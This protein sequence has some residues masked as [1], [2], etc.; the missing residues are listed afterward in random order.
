MDFVRPTTPHSRPLSSE[1]LYYK[2]TSGF[3]NLVEA[4]KFESRAIIKEPP[5]TSRGPLCASG[6][7]PID[8]QTNIRCRQLSAVDRR[9]APETPQMGLNAFFDAYHGA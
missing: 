9:A 6:A 1:I 5:M 3:A 4:S 8:P 7:A 2:V